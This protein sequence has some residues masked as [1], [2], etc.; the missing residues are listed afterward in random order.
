MLLGQTT[1]YGTATLGVGSVADGMAMTLVD[2]VARLIY[3]DDS[4]G[5]ARSLALGTV[6]DPGSGYM[7]ADAAPSA[8]DWTSSQ[9]GTGLAFHAE[10]SQTRM[11]IFEAHGGAMTSALIGVSG[12]PGAAT[13]VSSSTG[14]LTGVEAMTIAAVGASDIAILN[15]WGKSGVKLYRVEDSGFLTYAT[16]LTDTS[17]TYLNDVSDTATVTL[18]GRDYLLT[19]SA[20]E[21]GI[22]SFAMAP[23][24][25]AALI[26][27][28]GN[29][30]GLAVTGPAS[31]QTLEMDGVTYAVIASTGSSSLSVVRINGMGCL[32]TVDHVVDDLTTRFAQPVALDSFTYNGRSFIVTAGTDAGITFF[33]MLPGGALALFSTLVLET[34]DGIGSVTSL[35]IAVSGSSASLF[36][37]D[38]SAGSILQLDFSLATLGGRITASGGQASGSTLDDLILGTAANET[39]RGNQ[40]ADFIH[41]GAGADTLFGG[42]GADVFVLGLDSSID[43]IGD[44]EANRD[45]IDLSEWGRFYTAG[46]LTIVSTA[47]GAEISFGTNRVIVTSNTGTSLSAASFTD[48]DFIF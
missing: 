24:G 32:F 30:D 12:A 1:S 2:G 36:V 17:K 18:D 33:E 5:R 29:R 22:S 48:S 47:T 39:L 44:Y 13:T 16:T 41:D 37:I 4:N 25:S 34:G 11:Y 9:P 38:D 7:I 42:T 26:D 3:V 27:S 46:A 19:L 10:G 8:Q 23:D 28:L 35:E 6:S 15:F 45:L 43:R 21:N 40:G 31:L 20:L 14:T